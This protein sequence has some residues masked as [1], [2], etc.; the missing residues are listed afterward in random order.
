MNLKILIT[1]QTFP[2][3]STI[4]SQ[5]SLRKDN[6]IRDSC[7]KSV[8]PLRIMTRRFCKDWR[9]LLILLIK[10][11]TSQEISSGK[12]P[13]KNHYQLK[14]AETSGRFTNWLKNFPTFSTTTRWKINNFFC[15]E[16]SWSRC[17]SNSCKEYSSTK[18]IKAFSRTKAEFKIL[19]HFPE[20][21]EIR[22]TIK[23]KSIFYSW[24]KKYKICIKL[25]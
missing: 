4:L 9:F 24:D 8:R 11:L 15:E 13:K 7:N 1:S 5:L 19:N 3:S 20:L 18:K 23:P 10:W 14:Y 21:V 6:T 12:D 16:I 17:K 22:H 2:T 25:C